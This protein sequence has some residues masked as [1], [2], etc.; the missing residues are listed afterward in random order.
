LWALG[1]TCLTLPL[2][3]QAATQLQRGPVS[4]PNSV[5]TWRGS[6]PLQWNLEEVPFVSDGGVTLLTKAAADDTTGVIRVYAESDTRGVAGIPDT[7]IAYASG[8]VETTGTVVGTGTGPVNVSFRFAFD[9]SFLTHSG[10]SFHQLGAGL[11]VALPSTTVPFTNVNY[12][13]SMDFRTRLLDANAIDVSGKSELNYFEPGFV[14]VTE[15]YAGGRFEAVE[16]RMDGV[17]G[18]LQLDM[19]LAPGQSFYFVANMF[20]QSYSEPLI[21]V[22]NPLDYS[23]SWGTVDGFSTGTL[24]IVLPE[25]YSLAGDAGLLT[26]AVV[27]T[28][29]PEPQTYGLFGAGLATLLGALRLRRT[30]RAAQVAASG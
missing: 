3:V 12:Q 5:E 20:A 16:T 7:H 26:N 22:T 8:Q 17:L 19:A 14:P 30:R 1:I 10:N 2:S 28:P 15:S 29:V 13:V 21:P 25:G 11:T 27:T 6:G 24:S 23:Q 4:T 9:G 18:T